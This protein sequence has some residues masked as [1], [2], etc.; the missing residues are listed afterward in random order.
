MLTWILVVILAFALRARSRTADEIPTGFYNLFE[1]IIEGAYNF[2]QGIAGS[3]IRDFFPYFMSFLL[4]IMIANWMELVPGID[5]IGFWDGDVGVRGAI[6][7][8]R[9]VHAART[10]ASCNGRCRKR[11]AVAACAG[12]AAG[13]VDRRRCEQRD[14]RSGFGHCTG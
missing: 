11:D 1:L 5:S 14:R 6:A 2:A 7:A 13:R 9:V 4:I 10:L 3:K 8:D 12:T